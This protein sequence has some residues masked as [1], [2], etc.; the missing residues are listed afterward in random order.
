MSG[1]DIHSLQQKYEKKIFDLTQLLEI[2]RSLASTLEFPALIDSILYTCMSRMKVLNVGLFLKDHL[3]QNALELYRNYKGYNVDHRKSYS[4]PLDSDC[5]K[6]FLSMGRACTMTEILERAHPDSP[7]LAMMSELMPSL[8]VP[9]RLKDDLMGIL[10]LGEGPDIDTF[11][12]DQIEYI[13]TICL[14]AAAAVHNAILYEM[15]TT[16]MMTQLR[17]RN[18]FLSSMNKIFEQTVREQT[19]LSIIFIDIDHFKRLND[20]YGHACGDYMLTQV[21][22]VLHSSIRKIDIGCRYGGDECIILLPGAGMEMATAVAERIRR[23]IESGDFS[24]EG[25][26]LSTTISAG[27]AELDINR[28]FTSESL[29]KRADHALYRAKEKGRNQTVQAD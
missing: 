16:D 12:A 17:L 29:I 8:I 25:E 15:A 13:Q 6:M 4:I 14:F 23:R 21:A 11:S 24:Y 5:A 19:T 22:A 20:T 3:H 9:L 27:V 7:Q 10:I 18:F 1:I 26:K 28:D 2:S